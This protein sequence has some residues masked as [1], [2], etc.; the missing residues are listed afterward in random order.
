V[1]A[2]SSPHESRRFR[3]GQSGNPAGRKPGSRNR[4]TM[5]AEALLEGEGEALTRKAIELALEGDT[6]ALK[7]CLERVV[8]RR[9][10]R[11]VAFAVPPIERVEDLAPAIG[12]IFGEVADGKLRLDEG[13]ALVGMLEAKR[14]AMETIDLEQRL[15]AL[16]TQTPA[17]V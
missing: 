11:S 4:A 8:P 12:A 2:D 10:S 3:K 6:T 17:R 16:E 7:L 5:A 15:R 1:I 13:A 14:R 9:R